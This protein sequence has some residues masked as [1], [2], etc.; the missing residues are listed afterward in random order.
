MWRWLFSSSI[1]IL[2]TLLVSASTLATETIASG[3]S[4]TK[5][6]LRL[7]PSQDTQIDS[8][9]GS[10]QW[11]ST[12]DFGVHGYD[13]AIYWLR[14]TIQ[15]HNPKPQSLIVR[16]LYP[17]HDVIDF[18]RF[19]NDAIQEHWSMGDT[20]DNPGW[21]FPDKNFAIPVDLNPNQTQQVLIRVE[22]I[23]TKMLKTEVITS[24][25]LQHSIH[26]TRLIFGAIYGIMLAMALYNLIIGVFVRDKAYIIYACQVTL[27]CLF[28]MTINGDGRYYLWPDFAEFNHYAIQVFGVLYVFFIILF[29]WY[30]LK[31]DKYLPKAKYMFYFFWGVELLFATVVLFLPY[32][33]SMQIAVAISALFSPILLL[34]GLYFVFKK[35]PIAGIYTFAWSF[36]LV[37]ATLVGLAAANIVEMNIFTLNGGALGGI[38][39]QI[40]LSIA[41]A[42]RIDNERQERYTALKKATESELEATKQKKNFQKLFQRSPV[43]I[44][45]L[46]CNGSVLGINPK[47]LEL[48]EIDSENAAM[49]NTTS[50]YQ[51][52]E[53]YKQIGDA[54]K[55][56]GILIDYETTFT[57]NKGNQRYCTVT[58][59]QQV[60]DGNVVY[61]SYITDISE[62]KKVQEV[63]HAMEEERMKTLEQLVTGVAHEIN[64]PL[65]NSLT[66][67]SFLKDELKRINLDFS[68]N[69]VT[70]GSF[71]DYIF[72]A[73]NALD[74]MDKGLHQIQI[75]VQKFKQ[76]SFKNIEQE[77]REFNL[78]KRIVEIFRVAL[79]DQPHIDFILNIDGDY[80]VK[81]LPDLLEIIFNQLIENSVIHGFKDQERGEIKLSV[82]TTD[83]IISLDYHDNGKG[84][85]DALKDQIF[86]P[87]VTSN[88][89]DKNNAGL[90]LYRIHNLVTQALSGDIKLLNEPGFALHI[91]FEL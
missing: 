7:D 84:V 49:A 58:L 38:V 16:P 25:Q 87:F 54:V 91:Q 66:S 19:E 10:D 1:S 20:L 68:T 50:F 26:W 61:E 8:A 67:T 30:L 81:T 42:K 48:F 53:R 74:I 79:T 46:D 22:G 44:V 73:D 4:V 88:R 34:A 28:I 6:L 24:E 40:L 86:N 14:L 78:K 83:N 89:G 62:R 51:Y 75:L 71:G 64:T 70:K 72:K 80:K 11:Q 9:L 59:I 60:E 37:G 41:L 82:H 29:P 43:G 13:P 32:Q 18:Y 15:S 33:A 52:F 21:L 23:N 17:L 77:K 2:L 63:I 45:I 31:L 47:C 57:T 55:K 12:Q 5:E 90:G 56:N 69:K 65:G 36:Y 76:V 3:Y 35:V 27:F 85:D 39:E